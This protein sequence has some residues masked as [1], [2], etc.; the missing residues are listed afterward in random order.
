MG[1]GGPAYDQMIFMV[2]RSGIGAKEKAFIF[3]LK[4]SAPA[5]R[6]EVGIFDKARRDDV[7]VS[8]SIKKPF[9]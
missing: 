7:L 9:F 6:C 4:R 3:C 5:T 8:S 1:Y 2:T